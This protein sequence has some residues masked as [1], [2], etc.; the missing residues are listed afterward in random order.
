MHVRIAIAL[1]SLVIASAV[2]GQ[3]A[4]ESSAKN[5]L[6]GV[7]S[8]ILSGKAAEARLKIQQAL[9]AYRS[10]SNRAGE[11]ISRFFLGMLY[12]AE[13]KPVEAQQ[14]IDA[15]VSKLEEAGDFMS[16]VTALILLAAIENQ[17]GDRAAALVHHE[18]ALGMLEAAS[19]SEARFSLAGLVL[20][21]PAVGMNTSDLD[22]FR[23]NPEI[24]KPILLL[25]MEAI[26][27]DG[28]GGLLTS[29]G[30]LDDAERELTHA[31]R[32]AVMFGGM[33]DSSIEGHLGQLRRRQW[34]FD[35]AREHHRK[36]LKAMKTMPMIPQRDESLRL[37]ILD[38]L[39]NIELLSG[40]TDDAL[41]WNDQAL[42][43]VRASCD[44]RREAS[45][46]EAR[47]NLLLRSSRFAEA[48][49][50]F[51]DALAT[52]RG[53]GE[54][55]REASVL[56]FLG[57]LHM[58]RGEYGSSVTSFER[59]VALYQLV[60]SQQ[61]EA[62]TW[63]NLAEAYILLE[64]HDTARGALE[65]ARELAKSS[66]FSLAG[67]LVEAV[68]SMS[69]LFTGEGSPKEVLDSFGKWWENPETPDLMLPADLRSLLG[70]VARLG[71]G[72]EPTHNE[73][74]S[75]AAQRVPELSAMST[76]L[77]G[78]KLFQEG[79]ITEA[80]E[81][82][83]DAAAKN[84]N[85]DFKAG[86]EA[87][88]GATYWKEGKE[89][90]AVRHF[91]RAVA[92][93]G[94]VASDVKVEEML[95]G[96]LGSN[97]RVYFEIAIE[98]L[99]RKGRVGEAFEHAERARSRAFLHSVGNARIQ[100]ARGAAA[101]LVAEAEALRKS[102][103]EWERAWAFDPEATRIDLRNARSRYE[104]LLKRIKASNPEYASLTTVEALH[105][106]DVQQ[107]LSND[108]SLISYFVT[109][110]RVHVWIVDRERI[111]HVALPLRSAD[112]QKAVCWARRLGGSS[113]AVRS[114]T[115]VHP[116]CPDLANAEDVHQMLFAP[117]RGKLRHD[118]LILVPHGVLHYMPFAAL[119]NPSNGRYLV[120]D[121]TISYTPSASA[122]R[123]LQE[124]E[125]PLNGGALV[126]GDP[127]AVS[128]S[129]HRLAGAQREATAIAHAFGTEPKLGPAASESLLYGLNGKYDLVHIGAHAEYNADQPIFSRVVLAKDARDGNLEVHEVLADV[130]LTGVNLLVLSACGTARG[131]RS[132]GDEIVGLTRAVL[133]AGAPGVITTLWDIDDQASADFM[134]DFYAR[135][136][137]GAA[138]AD[139]LRQAQV[140]TLKRT[141]YADPQ[142]WAAFELSGNPHARWSKPLAD[143]Y[144]PQT[145]LPAVTFAKGRKHA[146]FSGASRGLHGRPLDGSSVRTIGG[147]D[148]AEAGHRLR[149]RQLHFDGDG[150]DRIGS[151]ASPRSGGRIDARCRRS[152][153]GG[154][155]GT[156]RVRRRFDHRRPTAPGHR[157][158]SR[159]SAPGPAFGSAGL[160]EHARR[161]DEGAG[162]AQRIARRPET[163]R[164]D[165]RWSAESRPGAGDS[166]DARSK[167]DERRH[168]DL[169]AGAQ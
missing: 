61:E 143:H 128:G 37:G 166:S 48:K 95:A 133:Y 84:P 136:L 101:P 89:E 160:D 52:A 60:D 83:V 35:E 157:M 90:Q 161:T 140:A 88:V 20:I 154:S 92:A 103:E 56:S 19:A 3:H 164:S 10:E 2:F 71:S 111:E 29:L 31:Q 6:D 59:S 45:L 81:L 70:D 58:A 54:V 78:R 67:E 15:G 114:M 155:R 17:Q 156:R 85:T 43:V 97:R 82:F 145:H 141:P 96:Y 63:I 7:M 38:D 118:R 119:R 142:F 167:R 93:I 87:A 117:L 26:V 53:I 18:R 106:A 46:I 24:V 33:F 80:R 16:A 159:P 152:L 42:A 44:I 153:F 4:A 138:V 14:E 125:S 100:A 65:K 9:E 151:A 149:D 34:H 55:H 137:A 32:A 86:F 47:G 68:A 91:E 112:L 1:L 27:R 135:L 144:R 139:A 121:Y 104:V 69:R 41:A 79:R 5:G 165:H 39:A 162:D 105:L 22:L 147:A 129:Y 76:L 131:A 124:K 57:S 107:A 115:P 30:R 99:V 94:A 21:A 50:A 11:G 150:A 130:D 110:A 72:I 116:D 40:R 66:D 168:S 127:A 73:P 64:G 108:E 62:A 25:M 109:N 123:F 169:R 8:L 113:E 122:L 134:E 74:L 51:G 28:Y 13:S 132:G 146:E 36:A 120:E 102:I 163:H 12:L 98:S 77:R 158:G 75:A 126:L 49:K 23:L 148:V